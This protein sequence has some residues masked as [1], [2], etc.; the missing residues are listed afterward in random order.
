MTWW[1]CRPHRYAGAPYDL[2]HSPLPGEPH[3]FCM[4]FEAEVRALKQ[5]LTREVKAKSQAAHRENPN[6]VSRIYKEPNAQPVQMLVDQARVQVEE[7]LHDEN[8]FTFTATAKLKEGKPLIKP[9]GPTQP[10][11]I[12]EDKVW[13]NNLHELHPG[14]EVRRQHSSNDLDPNGSARQG[15]TRIFLG[16]NFVLQRR[17]H[18]AAQA[19]AI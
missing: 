10:I 4:A 13:V 15:Q 14:D 1:A 7:V 18:S 11:V 6:K 12:T 5:I 17:S 16:S 8:A 3:A 2:P 19:H 9:H